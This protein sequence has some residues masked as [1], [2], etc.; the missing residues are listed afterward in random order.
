MGPASEA[1]LRRRKLHPSIVTLEP[2]PAP[3]PAEAGPEPDSEPNLEPA[4]ER[5]VADDP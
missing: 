2:E 5:E 4:P 1:G 3:V